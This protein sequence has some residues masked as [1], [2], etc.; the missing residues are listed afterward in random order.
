MAEKLR[1]LVVSEWK[2][3]EQDYEEYVI[4]RNISNEIEKFLQNSYFFNDLGDI[5]VLAMA[6]APNI[7]ILAFSSIL[8]YPLILTNP[9]HSETP[10]LYALP[11]ITMVLDIMMLLKTQINHL[12]LPFQHYPKGNQELSELWKTTMGN[13]VV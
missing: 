6:N 13:P 2:H 1:E 4:G 8:H 9:R 10:I 12:H 5:V 7:P 3:N 11:S